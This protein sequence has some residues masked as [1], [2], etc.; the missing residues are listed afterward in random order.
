MKLSEARA[1]RAQMETTF[2]K[3]APAMTADEII[4]NRTLCKPWTPGV[5]T[6]GEV[7]TANGQPW[8]C[9]QAY[10]NAVYPDITPDNAAWATFNKPYHGTTAE[11]AL[12][13]VAP[14]HSGDIYKTGEC[15]VWTD[16]L[17]KRCVRDTSFGPDY[18]PDAW[19]DI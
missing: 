10:D 11:T 17:V 14:T 3:A 5:H 19:E 12:P 2:A 15:M 9:Y 1:L 8:E 16:G 6:V 18:D 13:W 7:Y 4:S